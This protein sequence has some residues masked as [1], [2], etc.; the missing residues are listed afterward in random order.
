[1]A[2]NKFIHEKNEK[3]NHDNKNYHHL[4]E[5]TNMHNELG[6]DLSWKK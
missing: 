5:T 6:T 2:M 1:M 4:I 3:K